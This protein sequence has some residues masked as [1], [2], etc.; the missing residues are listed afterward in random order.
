MGD[1]VLRSLKHDFFGPKRVGDLKA[2]GEEFQC[3]MVID[4]IPEVEYWVRNLERQPKTSF[5]LPTSTDRFY[6]DFVAK[7]NDGRLLVVEYKGEHLA[8]GEDTLEKK[9][10]GELWESKST[11][12][13]LFLVV[14]K[15]DKNLDTKSQ[16]LKKIQ[17]D[18]H[19]IV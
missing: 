2:E 17:K 11:G 9:N 5:W 4:T 19:A 12:K 16:I 7:L 13:C 10:I 8:S 18:V 14:T 3:A 6:P 15:N 1:Q